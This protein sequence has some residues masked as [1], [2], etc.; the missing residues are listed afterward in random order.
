MQTTDKPKKQS[1]KN[2]NKRQ[3]YGACCYEQIRQRSTCT[4]HA[5][6]KENG[7]TVETKKQLMYTSTVNIIEMM[8]RLGL[9]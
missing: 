4:V 7:K 9:A 2:Q 5:A 3:S 1:R 6:V 8:Y